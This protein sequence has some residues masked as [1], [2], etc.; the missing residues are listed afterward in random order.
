MTTRDN[1]YSVQ[2]SGLGCEA[3]QQSIVNMYLW[4]L[5]MSRLFEEQYW[6][7]WSAETGKGHPTVQFSSRIL[8]PAHLC[9]GSETL[10]LLPSMGKHAKGLVEEGTHQ[11]IQDNVIDLY[12]HVKIGTQSR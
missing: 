9:E 4:D 10:P 8:T 7:Q 2:I 5:R 3:F 12:E 6:Q 11:Y 1:L